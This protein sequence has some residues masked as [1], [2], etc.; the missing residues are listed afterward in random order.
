M[1]VDANSGTEEK[2]QSRPFRHFL[3]HKNLAGQIY[4]HYC[5]METFRLICEMKTLRYSDI[6]MMNDVAEN[7]W[8]LASA[9]ERLERQLS[10]VLSAPF[11]QGFSAMRGL[12]LMLAYFLFIDMA[13][14]EVLS[15]RSEVL[16]SNFTATIGGELTFPKGNGPFPVVIMLHPCSGLAPAPLASL[17][18]HSRE[19]LASGFA[20]LILDSYGPRNLGNNKACGS[21]PLGFVRISDASNAMTVLQ[22]LAKIDKDNIFLLGQ[23]DGASAA[24]LSARVGGSK[25]RFRAVAAYYPGCERL[26]GVG[27]TFLSPT[28]IFVGEKDTWTPP[29]DCIKARH[30][31]IDTGA[32]L[33]VISYPNAHHSFDQPRSAPLKYSGHILE[34]SREA[35]VDSRKKYLEFF[36]KYLTPSIGASPAVATPQRPN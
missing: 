8:G 25:G 19:L 30:S 26:L 12:T 7:A 6:N 28:I 4:Y 5:S 32:E 31:G 34:Y 23:S 11:W 1:T 20:T 9:S 13:V 14:A 21:Q 17:Q 18:A 15:F 33:Q 22:G 27:V 16:P 29:T 2:V 3:Q 24:I 35:T 36:K 10:A